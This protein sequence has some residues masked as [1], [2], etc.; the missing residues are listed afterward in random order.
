[1]KVLITGGAGFIG[2]ALTR[3]ILSR[4]WS[5]IVVDKLTYAGRE[6]S[7][8]EVQD[9]ADYAF[10]RADIADRAALDGLFAQLQPD[11]VFHL[12][13]ETHVDRSIDS[14]AAFLQTNVIGT[15]AL[16]E[17]ARAYWATLPAAR[18]DAFRL[19]HVSTDEVFGALGEEG[20]FTEDTRYDPRS[21]YS[22]SKAASDHL[23]RAWNHT[24][25]LPTLISNCSNN[26][27][28]R[29][30]P[31]K[32]IPLI[33]LN[34]L[35]GSK[36]PVYGDGLNVRD[37]LH[38]DDHSRALL[39]IFERGAIARTYNV[40]GRSERTNMQVVHAV[41]DLLDRLAPKAASHRD[42]IEHVTD[43][44]GHDRRYAIDP[45]RIH[46]ELGW[47]EQETFES[48]LEK[49]V[50]WYIDNENWW[51]PLREA[52]HGKARLGTLGSRS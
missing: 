26:Y 9:H 32:L 8:A 3:Q 48:G 35:E 6:E 18:R 5:A 14:S 21:P 29:Q 31:E 44:P 22:A 43:R 47:R 15:H 36:L 17:A 34:G 41:C 2:S 11:G 52:G 23:V 24:Y 12:A 16:L 4:G 40:G 27:G 45:T 1:M 51:R 38:V 28:P 7:L 20:S 19:L 33:I 39:A 42:L 25:G 49:T 30:F 13:A 46:R 37:W 10:V 50:R